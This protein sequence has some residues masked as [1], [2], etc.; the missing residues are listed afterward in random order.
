VLQHAATA[1]LTFT[2]LYSMIR[3][4]KSYWSIRTLFSRTSWY[5][6]ALPRALPFALASAAITAVAH[7]FLDDAMKEQWRH[8]YPYQAFAFVVGF[9]LV[10][11]CVSVQRG[12]HVG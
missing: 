2:A 12:V 9:M 7:A 4:S 6:S 1:G 11:R 3:Y 10:F 5:G 8:P